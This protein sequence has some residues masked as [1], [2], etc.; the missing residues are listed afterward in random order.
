MT[1]VLEYAG[2]YELG[3]FL[4]YARVSKYLKKKQHLILQQAVSSGTKLPSEVSFSNFRKRF[5]GAVE[6]EEFI[7]YKE[8]LERFFSRH[9]CP[10]ECEVPL[11]FP[12]V[13]TILQ[14]SC[15]LVDPDARLGYCAAKKQRF[16][17]YRVQLLIDDKKKSP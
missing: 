10:Y 12:A 9:H 16:L 11:F 13:F 2:L 1:R 14:T 8:Y 7:A 5:Q 4:S 6:T 3:G 15:S 17:G